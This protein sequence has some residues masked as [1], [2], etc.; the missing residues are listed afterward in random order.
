MQSSTSAVS[1]QADQAPTGERRVVMCADDYGMSA[2][3][4]DAVLQLGRQGALSATSAMVLSP[5]WQEDAQRLAD[6]RGR[7]DVGL[8]LDWTSDF[9]QAAGH[10]TA[11][12][13]A[14]R[15]ALFGG[16]NQARARTE[17]ERQ[18][19]AF[20]AAWKSAPDHIDG[21]QHVQ[22]FSGIR[23]ALLEVVTRR[24]GPQFPWLRVS[25]PAGPRLGL[26]SKVIG[27]LGAN[28][29]TTASKQA[30]VPVSP[31]LSG[32]YD[33]DPQ[34]GLYE[35]HMAQWL[36]DVPDGALLMCH[37]STMAESGDEIGPARV[38]EWAFLQSPAFSDQLKAAG[39]RLVRGVA[40]F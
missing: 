18:L 14:M 34:E 36:A 37:P 1:S 31:V 6:L 11:L 40:V 12:G 27:A 26:K 29:L 7:L 3:V 32:I 19:D 23:Q 30:G 9:A 22:Q 20:E 13:G 21:H 8:H 15:R 4:T 25:R 24:Y 10:G 16:F 28:A 5:R 39:I 17:I 2:G 33:F 38:R 35:K